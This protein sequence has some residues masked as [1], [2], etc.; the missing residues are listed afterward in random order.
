VIPS[1]NVK[2]PLSRLQNLLSFRFDELCATPFYQLRSSTA[3]ADTF[4][5]MIGWDIAGNV[6]WQFVGMWVVV[7]LVVHFLLCFFVSPFYA[8]HV[9]LLAG[10][11]A[12]AVLGTK[13]YF[14]Q[15]DAS[16]LSLTADPGPD[17]SLLSHVMLIYQLF[18]LVVTWHVKELQ[19]AT[20]ALHH[21]VTVLLAVSSLNP[22][23]IY[24]GGYFFGVVEISNIPLTLRDVIEHCNTNRGDSP[25]RFG[26]LKTISEGVFVLCFFATRVFGWSFVTYAFWVQT[27]PVVQDADAKT[28]FA[29][30]LFLISNAFL[31]LLQAKWS[32]DILQKVKDVLFSGSKSDKNA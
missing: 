1:T 5:D 32:I 22:F 19:S 3:M 27:L 11:V 7:G 14:T 31:T 30:L 18:N 28:L 16:S 12:L 17:Q 26:L 8:S 24:Y 21:L 23:A 9:V 25:P 4:A 2:R 15:P 20:M 10:S 6:D 13:I 29:A